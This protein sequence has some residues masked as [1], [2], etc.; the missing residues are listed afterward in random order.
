M[1]KCEN[2]KKFIVEFVGF[3]S[4]VF[5]LLLFPALGDTIQHTYTQYGT[6]YEVKENETLIVDAT[7]NI[8]SVYDTDYTEGESVKIKFHDN[9]TDFNRE[10]DE[11]LKVKRVK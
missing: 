6:V 11:I 10:D 2:V 8:W 7:D 9:F 4:V 3:T 5:I 1:F